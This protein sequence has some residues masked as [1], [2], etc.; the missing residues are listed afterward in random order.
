[1]WKFFKKRSIINKFEGPEWGIRVEVEVDKEA[2]ELDIQHEEGA[3]SSLLPKTVNQKE[4]ILND[5]NIYS[6]YFS[7]PIV[8]IE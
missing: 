8:S 4:L 7:F 6:S 2:V 5:L 1:M 3:E